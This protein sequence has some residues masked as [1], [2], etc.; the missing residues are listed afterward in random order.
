MDESRPLRRSERPPLALWAIAVLALSPF[1][2]SA[3]MYAYGP[4]EHQ[5]GSLTMLMSWSALVVAFIG[6]VRWGL[7]TREH[8][9]RWIRLAF[10]AA[11]AGAA[12]MLLLGRGVIGDAWILGLLLALFMIQWLFDHQ[13][14]DAPQRYPTLS[15]T[16][17]AAACVSLA[18]ALEKTL[19]A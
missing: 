8:K 1:P 6:G 15:T 10:N 2:S 19:S 17:T 4:L 7:E 9:P 13:S 12:W 16:L 14:P 11:C 3:V 5:P 18:L